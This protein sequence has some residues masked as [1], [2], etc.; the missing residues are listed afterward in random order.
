MSRSFQTL[1][2]RTPISPASNE[3]RLLEG[4]RRQRHLSANKTSARAEA[5]VQEWPSYRSL[6]ARFSHD[7][8]DLRQIAREGDVAVYEQ[9]FQKS[10]APSV[11]Y[12]V[13]RLRRREEFYVEDHL[14]EPAEVYPK[15]DAWGTDGFTLTDRDAAFAKLREISVP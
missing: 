9:T 6:E 2:H 13:I 4:I 3:K 14:V 10:A 12:E 15:A 5:Q 7:G 11:A 8:F 1:A